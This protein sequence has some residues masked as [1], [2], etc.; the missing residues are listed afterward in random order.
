MSR[1]SE[2]SNKN[3][4]SKNSQWSQ[5]ADYLWDTFNNLGR[6][7]GSISFACKKAEQQYPGVLSENDKDTIIRM[8]RADQFNQSRKD[9]NAQ[10]HIWGG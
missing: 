4:S 8:A 2:L 1:L 7:A 10:N 5:A 3:N 9:F 6:A